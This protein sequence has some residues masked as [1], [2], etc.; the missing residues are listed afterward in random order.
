[1]LRLSSPLPAVELSATQAVF[2]RSYAS[3]ESSWNRPL[4]ISAHCWRRWWECLSVITLAQASPCWPQVMPVDIDD[5]TK[6]SEEQRKFFSIS[7]GSPSRRRRKISTT[8]D[9]P[10]LPKPI[11]QTSPQQRAAST[12]FPADEPRFSTKSSSKTA[13]RIFSDFPPSC[14]FFKF[15]FDRN[16]H[17]DDAIF[18][19]ARTAHDRDVAPDWCITL[20]DSAAGRGTWSR[21]LSRSWSRRR[22]S[23]ISM[24]TARVASRQSGVTLSPLLASKLDVN[25]RPEGSYFFI[26]VFVFVACAID[27]RVSQKR[28]SPRRGGACA[29]RAT[30]ELRPWYTGR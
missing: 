30:C 22:S 20:S 13:K 11:P 3:K 7:A 25:R 5:T 28:K 27:K 12:H 2:F 16:V 18:F 19:C 9:L 10:Y 1:M 4:A 21:S 15:L 29:T 23:S 17:R 14:S 6:L 8:F 24:L 26:C